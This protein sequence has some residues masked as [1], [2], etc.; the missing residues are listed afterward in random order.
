MRKLVCDRCKAEIDKSFSS[1]FCMNPAAKI[2]VFSKKKVEGTS[3][4]EPFEF[5][6]CENCSNLVVD[7]VKN[8][9]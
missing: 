1:E 5:D 8:G 9:V 3:N 7:F 2:V 6:L 4:I